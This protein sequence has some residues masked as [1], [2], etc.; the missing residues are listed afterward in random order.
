MGAVWH[1]AA[2]RQ[3]ARRKRA[4]RSFVSTIKSYP[5][6]VGGWNARDALAEMP[7]SDAVA[8]DNWM[9][10]TSYCEIRGGYTSFATGITGNGKTLCPYN[11]MNGTASVFCTTANGVY[12][13]TSAGAVGASVAARTNGKHQQTMFGDI[14]DKHWLILVNGV[15]KPL[16]YDGSTWTAVDSGSTPALTGLTTTSIIGVGVFKGRLLFLEKNSLSFWYLPSGLAGGALLEFDLSGEASRGGYLMAFATWTRDAGDGQD[17]YA[18]FITSE[19]QAIVYQGTNPSS[20]SFWQKTG[21]YFI[22]RPLGRRCVQQYGGDIVVLTQNGAVPL[23]SAILSSIIDNR[24]A[25]SFKIENAFTTASGLYGANFGWEA[26]V[27]PAQSALIVNIPFAEDGV[28]Y[29]YVMN[30]ITKAWCRFIGWDAETFCISAGQLY[31]CSGT[32]VYKA[33]TGQID[34]T[35]NIIAYGKQAFTYFGA[36]G[37]LKQ[38]KLYRPVLA[39]NGTLA[40]LTDIDVDFKDEAISGTATYTPSATGLWSVS[41]WNNANWAG[42]LEIIKDWTSPSEWTGTAVSGKIK[43]STG[44]LMVQWIAND[45]MYESVSGPVIG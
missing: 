14:N 13:V 19:G 5:A 11:A 10:K 44:S 38:Y 1:L 37:T 16:Y 30:T 29:Q 20:S 34:G 40:F 15:D 17:D 36:P 25:L 22:G 35:N 41:T 27:Y 3:P 28:H 2:V 26:I 21:S 39:V 8:L 31:F 23:S 12:D 33:W 42:G 24:S 18:V 7:I 4:P 6:P 45:M 9:P 32:T 43:I